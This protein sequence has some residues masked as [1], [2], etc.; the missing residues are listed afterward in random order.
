MDEQEERR[1]PP[2]V[3]FVPVQLAPFLTVPRVEIKALGE[4][5]EPG[6]SSSRA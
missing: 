6:L 1:T 3:Q 2:L 4:S 5:T